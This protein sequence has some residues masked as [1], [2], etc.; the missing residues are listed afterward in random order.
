MADA[1]ANRAAVYALLGGDEEA[2]QDVDQ[3]V[4]LGFDAALLKQV[5]EELKKER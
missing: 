2:Q 5:I 1:Y 4:A 3:A